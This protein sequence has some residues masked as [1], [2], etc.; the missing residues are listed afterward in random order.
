MRYDRRDIALIL[1][2][3]AMM[4]SLAWMI[5][6]PR[7]RCHEPCTRPHVEAKGQP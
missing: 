7:R 4:L 6:M 5:G 2:G 1:L 3:I